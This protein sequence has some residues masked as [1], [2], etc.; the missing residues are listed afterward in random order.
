MSPS[1]TQQTA[2]VSRP[3]EDSILKCVDSFRRALHDGEGP[4]PLRAVR[5]SLRRAQD[6]SDVLLLAEYFRLRE[7]I[8][9]LC[10]E[11]PK[12][13]DQ[14]LPHLLILLAESGEGTCPGPMAKRLAQPKDGGARPR[15]SDLRFRKLLAAEDREALLRRLREGV[16]L[17]DRQ[18]HV[19]SVLRALRHWGD[20]TRNEWA[21]AYYLERIRHGG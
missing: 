5:A 19:P 14:W 8:A 9:A 3:E 13:I 16:R 21:E 12:R 11:G 6:A 1:V 4:R 2:T 18:L 15:C 17:A 20:R 7:E 10:D